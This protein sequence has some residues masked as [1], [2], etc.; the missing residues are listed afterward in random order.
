MAASG[1]R[2]ACSH[3]GGVA[4]STEGVVVA[5]FVESRLAEVQSPL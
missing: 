5:N 2:L 1:L 3:T 4:G